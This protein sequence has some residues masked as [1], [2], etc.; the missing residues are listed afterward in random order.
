[1]EYLV[2]SV[3][4]DFLVAVVVAAV[5]YLVVPVASEAS[6]YPAAMAMDGV[7]CLPEGEGEGGGAT[8]RELPLGR[9]EDQF[10]Y[11]RLAQFYQR[12]LVLG[13]LRCR[14]GLWLFVVM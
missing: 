2:V 6:D 11:L 3:A 14:S 10:R 8:M 13:W 7:K 4:S 5:E 12:N 9:L 1:V